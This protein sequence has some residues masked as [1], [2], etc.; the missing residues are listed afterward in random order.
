MIA[1]NELNTGSYIPGFTFVPGITEM[2]NC[3][4]RNSLPK[5]AVIPNTI[6]VAHSLGVLFSFSHLI[7]AVDL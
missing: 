1:V 5:P 7:P 6:R 3:V 2:G 4:F